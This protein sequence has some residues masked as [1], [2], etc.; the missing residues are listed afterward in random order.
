MSRVHLVLVLGLVVAACAPTVTGDPLGEADLSRAL[1]GSGTYTP[2]RGVYEALPT[3]SE[4]R[5]THPDP[6]V[7]EE[8]FALLR[9]QR[10]AG[11]SVG[12]EFHY[13]YGRYYEASGDYK[14]AASYYNLGL[15]ALYPFAFDRQGR[16][17][18]EYGYRRAEAYLRFAPDKAARDARILAE[19]GAPGRPGELPQAARA[20]ALLVRAEEVLGNPEGVLEAAEAFYRSL[21]GVNWG[22][23]V[24]DLFW[25]TTLAKARALERLGRLAEAREVYAQIVSAQDLFLPDEV[26][27]EAREAL[28]RLGAPQTQEAPASSLPPPPPAS[29]V[30]PAVSSPGKDAAETV[31]GFFEAV[32]ALDFAGI[33]QYLSQPFYDALQERELPGK[34]TSEMRE[35]ARAIRYEVARV[36]PPSPTN[37]LFK[38]EVIY[39]FGGERKLLTLYLI[40]LQDRGLVLLSGPLPLTVSFLLGSVDTEAVGRFLKEV[41]AVLGLP[42]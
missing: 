10:M 30:S 19:K 9:R 37:P 1:P 40:P 13:L 27:R 17:V 20:Y 15:K 23:R 8:A 16:D 12:P 5:L 36:T 3:V 24:A 4:E 18:W 34:V 35:K 39:D 41:H 29:P 28:V 22:G 2:P 32:R 42:L 38:A 21:Q 14:S 33:N 11:D 25:R 7:R 6:R 26:R 31:K